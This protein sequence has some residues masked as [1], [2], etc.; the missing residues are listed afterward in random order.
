MICQKI[1]T[2][3]GDVDPHLFTT[4]FVYLTGIDYENV[5]S[6]QLDLDALNNQ[7]VDYDVILISDRNIIYSLVHYGKTRDE[8]K[9]TIE[10]INSYTYL[11][12][13][14]DNKKCQVYDKN[15]DG[16]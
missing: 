3:A 4:A 12:R 16:L 8:M 1:K 13:I 6:V 15:Q 14:Y 9:K 2:F 5:D 11:D 7:S 10:N